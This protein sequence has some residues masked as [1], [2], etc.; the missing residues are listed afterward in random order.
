MKTTPLIKIAGWTALTVFLVAGAATFFEGTQPSV[1]VYQL[2]RLAKK[3]HITLPPPAPLTEAERAAARAEAAAWK[4]KFLAEFPALQATP[5]PVPPEEN[6]FLMLYEL[7][8][9]SISEEFQ[10]T[11]R[12]PGTCDPEA[13]QRGLAEHAGI[14]EQ[15]EKIGSLR[16]RSTIGIPDGYK[17]FISAR[18]AKQSG[19]ILL[20][21]A[22]LAAKAGDE[23]ESLR[24]VNAVGNLAEHFHDLETPTYLTETVA[25][26]MD[27]AR[28]KLTFETLL[29]ELGKSADLAKWQ[30]ELGRLDYSPTGFSKIHRGEWDV[31]ADFLVFPLLVQGNKQGELPDGEAIA[32]IH[33]SWCN[34]TVTSLLTVDLANL[35]ATLVH[36]V[37]SGL[38]EE[39]L[40][41]L[42][43]MSA[44]MDAWVGGYVRA[45]VVTA[46]GRAS[47]ELL[48]LEKVEGELSEADAKR[49]SHDPLTGDPFDFDPIKRELSVSPLSGRDNVDPLKL[50]W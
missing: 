19:D 18:P 4:V 25:I 45:A 8:N 31:A 17:G 44:G 1:F 16:T 13:A 32:R 28:Q 35:K 38:S 3:V 33:S 10:E 27:L 40:E 50:P 6:G 9:L 11:L 48:I 26:L 7:G 29:P 37:T 2:R 49:V 23:E 41:I 47:M 42:S 21:K 14:V 20:L 22:S 24:C 39:G 43:V 12:N 5:H 15:A 30:T 34:A 36:P 46:Q